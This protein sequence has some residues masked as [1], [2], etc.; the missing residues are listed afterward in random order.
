MSVV[1]SRDISSFGHGNTDRV[2]LTQ[3]RAFSRRQVLAV[4]ACII[5]GPGNGIP[6]HSFLSFFGVWSNF[7]KLKTDDQ[8]LWT[9]RQC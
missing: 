3:E 6:L 7:N 8:W 9:F 5:A 1:I 4:L 2:D